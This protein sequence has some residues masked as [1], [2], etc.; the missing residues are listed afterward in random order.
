MLSFSNF[1][2]VDHPFA[3]KVRRATE[4]AKERAPGLVID[5]EM[6]LATALD[7]PL[8]REYFPFSSLDQDANV[9]VFPDLQSGNLAL[10]LLQNVGGAVPIGPLL[11]GTRLPAHLLQYGATVEE[12]VNLV[13]VGA[14]EAA[15]LRAAG[16]ERLR[17][18]RVGPQPLL[19]A[20]AVA[21]AVRSPSQRASPAGVALVGF[22]HSTASTDLAWLVPGDGTTPRPAPP[23]RRILGAWTCRS[24]TSSSRARDLRIRETMGHDRSESLRL[25][26]AFLGFAL[27]TI[28]VLLP[29]IGDPRAGIG[30]NLGDPLFNLYVMKWGAHQL[31]LGLPDLWNPPFFFPTRGSLALS[32]HLI[33]PAAAFLALR[34]LGLPSLAAYNVL[35]LATFALSGFTA[36]WVL[37]R[38]GVSWVGALLGGWVFAFSS[39]RWGAVGH[40]QILHMQWI[41]PL[42]WFF[43]RVL[44]RPAPGSALGFL[45]F[46]VLH[47]TGGTYLAH[48]VH[49]PLAVLLLNR[50]TIHPLSFREPQAWRVWVPVAGAAALVLASVYVPYLQHL[51]FFGVARPVE[52]IRAS[53]IT[54]AGFLKP[55]IL[56]MLHPVFPDWLKPVARGDLY[57]GTAALALVALAL[58]A[59]WRRCA[60]HASPR[61]SHARRIGVRM[62]ELM[63]FAGWRYRPRPGRRPFTAGA[64]AVVGAVL[65]VTGLLLADRFTLT[66]RGPLPAWAGSS[67][68]GY[69]GPA[70]LAVPGA[71]V[72]WL[73]VRLA[74]RGPVLR[75]R[76]MPDWPRGLLA[77]GAVSLVLCLPVFFWAAQ[78][79]VPGM[80]GMRV[81]ARAFA[82]V[83]LP[84]AYLVGAGWDWLKEQAGA[85]PRWRL[86]LPLLALAVIVEGLP[87]GIRGTWASVP[88][89]DHFPGYARWIAS[90]PRK[91][92]RTSSCRPP[93]PTTARSW[94]CT[95]ARSTGDPWPTGTAAFSPPPSTRSRSCVGLSPTAGAS[96]T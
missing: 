63:V 28:V 75:W 91:S 30:P 56:S 88:E 31:S 60:R 39:F 48:L 29:A 11:M 65:L 61:R 37:R 76:D 71:L 93:A 78:Q 49:I 72:L 77:S 83:A 79:S 70:L 9:L 41:P 67:L 82:F 52:E 5:G 24:P 8:R 18:H 32:D 13:T 33:G 85:R 19:K 50:W 47:V 35:L 7:G 68:S 84:L 44:A 46:Y 16:V 1:G 36:C 59:G 87:Q 80:G 34:K 64:A 69:R 12:V 95:S 40:Y 42:L 10:H 3:R 22:L 27:A 89:E 66:G 90:T 4:L 21:I 38:S 45:F 14:V 58:H 2:S 86:A 81:P 92:A 55:S 51:P 57:P 73:G 53:G 62:G 15:S 43:D 74:W 20:W 6:Q 54:M 17:L 96:S 25:L 94:R 26:L 23:V